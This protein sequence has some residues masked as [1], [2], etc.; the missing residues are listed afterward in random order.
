M[1]TQL[2]GHSLSEQSERGRVPVGLEAGLVVGVWEGWWCG[3]GE[4]GG[5]CGEGRSVC[6][7]SC[8]V[9]A[10]RMWWPDVLGPRQCADA[11]LRRRAFALD[12]LRRYLAG[13]LKP[14]SRRSGQR[15]HGT[16][17]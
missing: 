13:S 1:P 15:S 7:G 5:R 3:G 8:E 17:M 6:L 4:C 10:V 12:A 14:W 2:S 16:Q 9:G 11:G